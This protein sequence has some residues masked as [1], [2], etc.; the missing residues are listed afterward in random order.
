MAIGT[1][2]ITIRLL[3]GEDG[4]CLL[5]LAQRDSSTPPVSPV[6]AAEVDGRLL[7]AVSLLDGREVADPCRRTQDALGLVRAR[8][9]QITGRRHSRRRLRRFLRGG[10]ACG[11][12]A[13]SP[14]GA[15]GKLLMLR[16]GPPF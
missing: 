9:R 10:H 1:E 15:G 13:G 4:P 14:P 8:A 16:A 2:R 6:L 11:A 5:K 3:G 7:A 12:L